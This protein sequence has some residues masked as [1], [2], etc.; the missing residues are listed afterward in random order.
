LNLDTVTVEDFAPAVGESFSL[1]AG[2]AG[3]LELELRA[4]VPASHPGPEGTRHPFTL[5]FRGPAEPMLPQSIY[6]L[7]TDTLGELE[8]FIV[9]VGR[10]DAGTAYEA[11]F[12]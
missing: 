2:Q 1:D 7:E 9:P 12:N 5:E 3:Q 10:D 8:F 6:R 11:V 4:A